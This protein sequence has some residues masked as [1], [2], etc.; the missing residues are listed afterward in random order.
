MQRQ[1]IRIHIHNGH[2]KDARLSATRF[3]YTCKYMYVRIDICICCVNKRKYKHFHGSRAPN[4]H[5]KEHVKIK[6]N[7]RKRRRGFILAKCLLFPNSWNNFKCMFLCD[8]TSWNTFWCC[9]HQE[10]PPKQRNKNKINVNKLTMRNQRNRN[11][12][13]RSE[14]FFFAKGDNECRNT[15]RTR[16][17]QTIK[18]CKIKVKKKTH[19][20]TRWTQPSFEISSQIRIWMNLKYTY[21]S[22]HE[23]SL[24]EFIL[25]WLHQQITSY[26]FDG[27]VLLLM[28]W[29]VGCATLSKMMFGCRSRERNSISLHCSLFLSTSFTVHTLLGTS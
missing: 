23:F 3:V 28:I 11:E 5:S 6:Q 16:T 12:P 27:S 24:C 26:C 21:E 15:T 1:I 19:E 29:F 17:K 13:K 7:I 9:L 4:E 10:P 2:D 20:K 22:F 25:R 18:S 14:H 8:E